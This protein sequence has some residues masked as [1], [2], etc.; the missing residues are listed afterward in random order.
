MRDLVDVMHALTVAMQHNNDMTPGVQTAFDDIS[1]DAR[2]RA[3]ENMHDLWQRLVTV[4]SEH[5]PDGR[6]EYAAIM[7]GPKWGKELSGR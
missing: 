3:P 2:Y 5:F 6:D 7:N 4:M 1:D